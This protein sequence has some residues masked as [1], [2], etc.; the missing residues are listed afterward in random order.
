MAIV[1]EYDNKLYC[2]NAERA[3]VTVIK[4]KQL[5]P[6]ECP[7]YVRRELIKRTELPEECD[8]DEELS[9]ALAAMRGDE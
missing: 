2:Y 9:A 3:V 4:M 1:V 8:E 7:E 6:G 5:S